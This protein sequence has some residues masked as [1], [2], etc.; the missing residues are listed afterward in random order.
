[1]TITDRSGGVASAGNPTMTDRRTGIMAGIAIKAPCRAASTAALTLSGEQTIDGVA[2]V[3]GDRVLVKDQ[4]STAT[5]GI[6]VVSTGLWS[7]ATDFDSVD[8]IAKG[9]LVYIAAGGSA[10]GATL[11]AV[12][13]TDPVTIDSSAITFADVT[14]AAVAV[15]AAPDNASYV[16]LGT[17]AT[18][19]SER[20]LTAGTNVSFVDGGAGTTLTVNGA[21]PTESLIIA[22]S[23]ESTALTT[24]TAKVKFR[25]PYAFTLTDVRASLSAAQTLGS[26]FTVDINENGSTILSTKLTIDNTETTSTTAATPRVISDSS[27]A[28][29][30]EISIDIDQIGDGNAKGLKVTLIGTRT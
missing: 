17:N 4:S 15:G 3:T 19:T 7:R 29:A 21:N 25:M 6:Y 20:V 26:I 14:E 5:N 1:M 24:G 16:T 27:L 22:C 13:S 10:N 23:D 8:E 18:L 2:C 9:T 30:A 12:S 28:D 11:W